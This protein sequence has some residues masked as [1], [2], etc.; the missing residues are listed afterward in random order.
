MNM[1][2]RRTPFFASSDFADLFDALAAPLADAARAAAT[3]SMPVDVHQTEHA[4]VVEAE[5]PGFAKDDVTVEFHEGVLTIAAS[6]ATASTGRESTP[7]AA[8]E[9]TSTGTCAKPQSCCGSKT[10][11]TRRTVLRE[12]ASV[13][14]VRRALALPERVTGEGIT[15]EIRDGLLTVILPFAARPTPRRI[16]VN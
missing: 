15:A 8:N 1:P 7:T 2:T 4:I 12:R 9:P 3:P 13:T 11:A 14:G 6:R 5:V 10:G 16:D